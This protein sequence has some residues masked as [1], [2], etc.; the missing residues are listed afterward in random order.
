MGWLTAIGDI[1]K[2]IGIALGWLKREEE[3]K[4]DFQIAAGASKTALIEGAINAQKN[5]EDVHSLSDDVLNNE[6]RA[7]GAGDRRAGS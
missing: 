5:R 4:D 6:L 7:S 1:F 2:T 3:K